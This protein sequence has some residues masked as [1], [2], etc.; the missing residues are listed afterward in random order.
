[1]DDPFF[2]PRGGSPSVELLQD[3]RV[4]ATHC[5]NLY[6]DFGCGKVEVSKSRIWSVLADIQ[7]ILA[8]N[9][10][11]PN[12][13]L[14][15]RASAT[16]VSFMLHPP[17]DI[18]F[19]KGRLPKSILEIPN[20]HNAIAGFEYCR[21]ALFNAKIYKKSGGSHVVT[22]QLS[23]V[24]KVS[25]HFYCDTIHAIANIKGDDS[26]HFLSLLYEALVYCD[27]TNACYPRTV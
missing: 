10:A 4:L 23:T 27:N 21:R 18:P 19:T 25:K 12:P 14:F 13:S 11:T 6:E 17:L 1:M 5:E 15:K 3:L 16:T 7:P 20:H 22:E 24:I 26:F 9:A 2:G 8:R